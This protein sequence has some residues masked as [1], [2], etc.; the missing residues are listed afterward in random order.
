MTLYKGNLSPLAIDLGIKSF[1]DI[2]KDAFGVFPSTAPS[3]RIG[4]R[5]NHSTL[6]SL[7][8]RMPNHAACFQEHF[9]SV[10][11]CEC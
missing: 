3:T 6:V 4:L 2:K 7:S 9:S 8:G 1:K 10:C 5:S 11:V